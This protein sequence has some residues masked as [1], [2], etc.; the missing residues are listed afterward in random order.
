MGLKEDAGHLPLHNTNSVHMTN[1]HNNAEQWQNRRAHVAHYL[2]TYSMSD[3]AIRIW[4]C[5]I[6]LDQ[7][8]IGYIRL[9]AR[10]S[11]I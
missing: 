9:G 3:W 7:V 4:L 11:S 1:T 6:G 8:R 2:E 10:M 5:W